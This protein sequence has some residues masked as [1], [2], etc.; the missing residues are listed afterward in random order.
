MSFTLAVFC[1][2]FILIGAGAAS[3][4]LFAS[5]FGDERWSYVFFPGIACRRVIAVAAILVSGGSV[6]H[7]SLLDPPLKGVDHEASPLPVLPG[8]FVALAPLIG[9]IVLL[10]SWVSLLGTP[11]QR[12]GVPG[13]MDNLRGFVAG[14]AVL[15][16]DAGETMMRLDFTDPLVWLFV[17]GGIN[18][19][20]L[21]VGERDDPVQ[22]SLGLGLIL[23]VAAVVDRVRGGV[24]AWT[25]ELIG[26]EGWSMLVVAVTLSLGILALGGLTALLVKIAR[27]LRS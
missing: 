13:G 1:W 20:T 19:A 9:S 6:T 7:A 16:V 14:V 5:I 17:Y 15:V 22:A 10:G 25:R 26:V 2:L 11:I 8:I 12:L 18:L 27:T 23:L 21:L 3:R 24:D 4:A